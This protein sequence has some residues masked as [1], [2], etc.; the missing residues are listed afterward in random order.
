MSVWNIFHNHIIS[1]DIYDETVDDI[2]KYISERK[3]GNIT[4]NG[5][6]GGPRIYNKKELGRFDIVYK[7]AT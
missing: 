3:D 6:V 7:G 5:K 2:D 4:V 1:V